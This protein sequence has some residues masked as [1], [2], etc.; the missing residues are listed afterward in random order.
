MSLKKGIPHYTPLLIILS[1]IVFC[2]EID[3]AVPSFPFVVNGLGTTEA[4]MQ[5]TM[6]L[7]FLGFCFGA[8]LYGPL[9][10][11]FGRRPVILMGC[12]VY[13]MGGIGCA[14]MNSI[15]MLLVFRLIQGLGASS[16][17]VVFYA[18]IA[19]MYPPK[20]VAWFHGMMNAILAGTMA[21]APILGSYINEVHG[22]R[23]PLIF[24]A[25][26]SVITL[27]G[28]VGFLPETN[29]EKAK[30]DISSILAN[31]KYLLT[32]KEFMLLTLGPSVLVGVY[33]TFVSVASFF[34]Q[35]QL[36]LSSLSFGL[37]QMCVLLSFSMVSMFTGEIN[38][39][40][41]FRKSI[42][43]GNMVSVLGAVAL[44]IL[45]LSPIKVPA[46]LTS[47]MSLLVIG[48][49]LSF[50]STI[51]LAFGVAPHIAGA[52]SSLVMCFRLLIPSL[53]IACASEIYDGTWF[54]I[55]SLM[56]GAGLVACVIIG[57][58]VRHSKSDL[59]Q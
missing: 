17:S 51:A 47:F 12:V 39:R 22:W 20:K 11:A 27:F 57:V 52:S 38:Q 4:L 54:P 7:N 36:D 13:V 15:E 25:A 18:M 40:F 45:S 32:N 5:L 14:L 44:F 28:I 41:G 56:L 16:G 26:L 2:T 49:A 35:T 48:I 43:W 50:G 23:A 29:K 19:D 59:L 6:S 10:D 8:L 55:A 34:Y 58:G 9:S 33:L 30:W 37:H 24:I 21:G 31:Y 46:L 42:L 53:M 3:L 1:F